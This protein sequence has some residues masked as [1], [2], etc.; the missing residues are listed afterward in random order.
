[1]DED[2]R[3]HEHHEIQRAQGVCG[4]GQLAMGLQYPGDLARE[5]PQID[6][7]RGGG[8]V[9]RVGREMEISRDSQKKSENINQAMADAEKDADGWA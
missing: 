7:L 9:G 2:R 8:R 6:D 1:M 5:G 3:G 4:E